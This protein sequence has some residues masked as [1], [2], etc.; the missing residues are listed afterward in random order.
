VEW[1]PQGK[2]VFKCHVI[3]LEQHPILLSTLIVQ[4]CQHSLPNNITFVNVQDLNR[5][6]LLVYLINLEWLC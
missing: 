3:M 2:Q 6:G 1:D 5:I 4:G